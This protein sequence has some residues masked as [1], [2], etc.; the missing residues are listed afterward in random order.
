MRRHRTAAAALSLLLALSAPARAQQP[1]A[2]LIGFTTSL[3]GARAT[4]GQ[5][6]L[7]GARLAVARANAGGGI[8]GRR[9]ELAVLDDGG[10]PATAAA[11]V[12]RLLAQGVVAL[13]G[14]HGAETSA[15]A[16]RALL[17]NRAPVAA[18][19]GPA[20][21]AQ[22]M[23]DPPLP[24]VFHL[25]AGLAEEAATAVLHLDT[26]GVT[27]Y[28]LVTQ[29]DGLGS[30]GREQLMVELTRIAIRPVATARLTAAAGAAALHGVLDEL[31]AAEPEALLLAV[32]GPTVAALAPLARQRRCAPQMLAFSEA[33]NFPVIAARPHPLSGL[34][35]TQVLPHPAQRSH[36]LVAEYLQASGGQAPTYP[37]L[38]GYQALRTLQAALLA[39]RQEPSR[40]C[41]LRRLT[42]AR[43]ELPGQSV[44]IGSNQRVSRPFVEITLLDDEGRFRR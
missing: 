9:L 16:A 14:P 18:L 6:L 3:S 42:T 26:I 37:A 10:S 12:R 21:G 38:E 5:G 11:N 29:D 25:R 31:C 27:R 23:R 44:Q 40:A 32:D 22:P 13:T 35:M 1:D 15:A 20:T 17:Q 4:F 2:V 24:G 43:L 30:S 36:P 33:G 39:C 7:Q 28:A 34:L 8:A 19:V 41:L